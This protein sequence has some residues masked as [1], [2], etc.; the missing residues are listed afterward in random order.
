M[1]SPGDG[2]PPADGAAHRWR[3]LRRAGLD[4]PTRRNALRSADRSATAECLEPAAGRQPARGVQWDHD[5]GQYVP[6]GRATVSEDGAFLIT[7]AGSGITKAGWGGLCV[8]DPDKCSKDKPPECNMC[9]ELDTQ[10]ECP[11]CV[12]DPLKEDR[13]EREQVGVTIE[14]RRVEGRDHERRQ[15]VWP[16]AQGAQVKTR[17]SG[18]T[19]R[20]VLPSAQVAGA[21]GQRIADHGDQASWRKA[22][23]A[24]AVLQDAED[25][26]RSRHYRRSRSVCS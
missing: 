20:P 10:R 19:H 26:G 4:D 3:A 1:V 8:Y 13:K 16:A 2:G 24:T 9:E 5:L 7:D 11:T 21:R 17:H 22:R 12:Y 25:P 14:P 18:W 23:S 15:S 6:M